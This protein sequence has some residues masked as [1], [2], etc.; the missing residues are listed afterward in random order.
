MTTIEDMEKTDIK[1]P[2]C[3]ELL[4]HNV[5]TSSELINPNIDDMMDNMPDEHITESISLRCKGC[6][7]EVWISEEQ[8][9]KH[10]LF[11]L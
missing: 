10:G 3:E 2:A 11:I 8:A 9:K 7:A 6:W 1:C 5:T 4:Y